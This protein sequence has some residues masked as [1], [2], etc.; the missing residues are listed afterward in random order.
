MRIVKLFMIAYFFLFYG[1][2]CFAFNDSGGKITKI[3]LY[4]EMAL[5]K[6]EIIVD[7]HKGENHLKFTKYPECMVDRSVQIEVIQKEFVKI[8]DIKVKRNYVKNLQPNKI[9]ELKHEIRLLD[10]K[11]LTISNKIN[12]IKTAIK[13]IKSTNPFPD[14]TKTSIKE[15]DRYSKYIIKSL[16]DKYNL[17]AQLKEEQKKL[18]KRKNALE[19]E[20]NEIDSNFN[21]SKDIYLDLYSDKKVNSKIKITYLV[22]SAKWKYSYDV[23]VDSHEKSITLY[24]F[25]IV[26]QSTGEDWNTVNMEISTSKPE[27]GEIPPLKPWYL[28]IYSPPRLTKSV[29]FDKIVMSAGPANFKRW[30]DKKE[31]LRNTFKESYVREN[32]TSFTFMLPQ[33]VSI[34]S[35]KKEH[36]IYLFSKTTKGDFI[37]FA[38]PKLNNCAQLNIE[39]KNPFK[40]PIMPGKVNVFLDGMFINRFFLEKEKLS[41]EKLNLSLGLDESIRTTKKLIKKYTQYKGVVSKKVKITYEYEINIYNGKKRKVNILVKDNIPVSRNEKIKVKLLYPKKDEVSISKEGIIT[42]K[43]EVNPYETKRLPVGF[44]IEYPENIEI[45]GL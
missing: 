13:F 41:G 31:I 27:K 45:I 10:R 7:L 18:I 22:K 40:Y 25:A 39:I 20:L 42:W 21:P 37:Y 17:I 11:I 23:R 4:P 14:N 33:K 19:N 2:L 15:V 28:D 26:Q 35:D 5:V 44:V 1:G 29:D 6:K 3:V 30:S 12:S 32:W 8:L 9:K 43:I 38:V 36:K 24:S 34:P 16:E